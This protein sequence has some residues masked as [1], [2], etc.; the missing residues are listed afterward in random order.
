MFT[1]GAPAPVDRMNER[2][3]DD[4]RM[5][6]ET[7][8]RYHDGFYLRLG[9]GGGYLVSKWTLAEETESSAGAQGATVPVELAIGG[10][11]S[12][13]VV[14][15]GGSWAVHVP[16]ATYTAGRGDFT[17]EETADYGS[18][19]MLGP[20][21]DVYPAPRFGAH[22]QFA[23]CLALVAP[24]TSSEI[25]TE[26]LSGTGFGAMV[27]VGYEGWVSDQWGMGLLVRNQFVYAQVTDSDD[28]TFDFV[29]FTPG[30][31]ITA[32]LH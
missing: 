13:G 29:G 16:S 27:G 14:I 4:V 25:V 7:G 21:V 30:A 28:N 18:I 17:S 32:T 19:S 6:R 10:T 31:L 9:V 23:P 8:K 3:E 24:G 1:P 2:D 5:R 15:G 26:E 12:P 11:P 20:F 22:L